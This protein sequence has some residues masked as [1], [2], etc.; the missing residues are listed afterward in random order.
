MTSVLNVRTIVL[1]LIR[2]LE[3]TFLLAFVSGEIFTKP[4]LARTC[5]TESLVINKRTKQLL[6]IIV[7]MKYSDQNFRSK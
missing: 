7:Q 3:Y 5:G 4:Y 1:Y 2:Y 6:L